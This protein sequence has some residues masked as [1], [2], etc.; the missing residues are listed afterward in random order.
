MKRSLALL[1]LVGCASGEQRT[2]ERAMKDGPA[3][4]AQGKWA[5]ATDVYERARHAAAKMERE[6]EIEAR[7]GPAFKNAYADLKAADERGDS[8]EVVRIAKLIQAAANRY[9]ERDTVNAILARGEI[10]VAIAR[11]KDLAKAG[12]YA[13]AVQALR[14]IRDAAKKNGRSE[15]IDGLA[16]EIFGNGM[17]K[18]DNLATAG[19]YREAVDAYQKLSPLADDFGRAD[20]IAE[21]IRSARTAA[22]DEALAKGTEL[23]EAGRWADATTTYEG[24]LG[25]ARELGR[26]DEVEGRLVRTRFEAAYAKAKDLENR[27]RYEEAIRAYDGLNAPDREA[28]QRVAKRIQSCRDAYVDQVCTSARDLIRDGKWSQALEMC[29]KAR[30]AAKLAGRE[31]DI[32]TI[33][34]EAKTGRLNELLEQAARA[35]RRDAFDE[36][37]RLLKDAEPLADDLDRRREVD[38][39]VYQV[40]K[41]QYDAYIEKG[42]ALEQAGKWD[43]AIEMY[44]SA[45]PLAKDLGVEKEIPA[46]IS[47]ARTNQFDA[48]MADARRFEKREQWEDAFTMY[49]RATPVAKSLGREKELRRASRW[50]TEMARGGAVFYQDFEVLKT[51]ALRTEITAATTSPA[52]AD[53]QWL[54]VG[55]AKG[56]LR[57][58]SL[59]DLEQVFQY[60]SKATFTDV[61]FSPDRTLVAVSDS[62]TRVRVFN[63]HTNQKLDDIGH[64]SAV[65]SVDYSPDGMY[66]V[67]GCEDGKVQRWKWRDRKNEARPAGTYSGHTAAVT[68]VR[69]LRDDLVVSASKDGTIRFWDTDTGECVR[70]VQAHQGACC[71]LQF[72]AKLGRLVSVGHEDH[73]VR[74]VNPEDGTIELEYTG[75]DERVATFDPLKRYIITGHESGEVTFRNARTGELCRTFRNHRSEVTRI[76]GTEDGR[77]LLTTDRAGNVC[78]WGMRE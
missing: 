33:E 8:A 52:H 21:K 48:Y 42:E 31:D 64:E 28:E 73:C 37:L 57:V 43:E 16:T 4:E 13:G 49:E 38:E 11:A 77:M 14:K 72:D 69:Y 20:E 65:N 58:F 74:V 12:D 23:E 22:L 75:S 17:K 68:V 41:D 47:K 32:A 6:P 15:E 59:E 9:G 50:T 18:A 44:E 27:G 35:R 62:F 34:T 40:Y 26:K 3:Y 71:S 1:I 56:R 30:A 25:Y 78:V 63:F 55:D 61:V 45:L 46:R 5:E 60:E 10:D 67:S 76:L 66:L 53:G 39:Q 54:A 51:I 29:R 2:F 7:E 19:R 36:A 24:A 70:T